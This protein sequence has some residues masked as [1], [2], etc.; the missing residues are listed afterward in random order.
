[1]IF[2]TP[3]EVTRRNGRL[4]VDESVVILL[5][6]LASS[7]D[8]FLAS[9]L[10]AELANQHGIALR[11]HRTASIPKT[12]RFILMGD[13]SNPLAQQYR[14]THGIHAA[15]GASGAEGYVLDASDQSV[16]ILGVDKPGAFYGLQTLRQV[17][18]RS[19]DG[20]YVPAQR[21]V[22]WP[23]QPFRGIYIFL[24]G[25]RHIPYFKRF[26]RE[27]MAPCKLNRLIVEM[28]AGMQFDRHPELNAG[29]I[30]RT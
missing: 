24:P 22:D 5:P 4:K 14:K 25:R 8:L 27:V 13:T 18:E 11:T 16:A 30:L 17:F 29:W 10:S 3:R 23:L 28:D 15:R 6:E 20:V 1:M 21:I 26:V 19:G 7:S 2:P 9:F 12:Q